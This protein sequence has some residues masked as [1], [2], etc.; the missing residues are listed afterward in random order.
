MLQRLTELNKPYIHLTSEIKSLQSV[1]TINNFLIKNINGL[2]CITKEELFKEFAKEIEFPNYF[3]YTWDSFDECICDLSW[4]GS[5]NGYILILSNADYILLGKDKDFTIFLDILKTAINSWANGNNE[6]SSIY[7]VPFHIV[8][9][10]DVGN[11][12]ELL[13]RLNSI[14]IFDSDIDEVT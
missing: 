1:Y 13:N 12:K 6:Q 8:L 7:Q 9:Q 3:G 2:N 4:F 10:C 11:K 14:G 5:K